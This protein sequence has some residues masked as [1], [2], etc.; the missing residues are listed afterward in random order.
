MHACP[1]VCMFI[2]I[3][4]NEPREAMAIE[5]ACVGIIKKLLSK[6]GKF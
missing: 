1:N 5:I 6:A 2:C 4:L 3:V